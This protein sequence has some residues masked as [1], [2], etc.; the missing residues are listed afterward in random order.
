MRDC[1]CNQRSPERFDRRC[2]SHQTMKRRA[3]C[4]DGGARRTKTRAPINQLPLVSFSAFMPDPSAM[5][6]ISILF[7][8][9]MP[10]IS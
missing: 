10:S 9:S 1:V 3:V 4:I 2:G 7:D 5:I 8:P 6:S